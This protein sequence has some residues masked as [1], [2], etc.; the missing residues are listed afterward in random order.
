MLRTAV[1]DPRQRTTP[2]SAHPTLRP[3]THL[4]SLLAHNPCWALALLVVLALPATL[5]LFRP[6][7]PDANDSL[8]HL[9][10]LVEFDHALRAG[11]PFPRWLPDYGLGHGALTTAYYA[12]G[13]Y[14]LAE[15]LH[16]AGLGFPMALNTALALGLLASG[17]A[18]YPLALA[19]TRR[20][21]AAVTAGL[22]YVYFPYHLTDVYT[23]GAIGDASA[24]PLLPLLL[25][26]TYRLAR[27]A[28]PAFLA[29]ASACF[30]LLLFTHE[31]SALLAAPVSLALAAWVAWRKPGGIATCGARRRR[32]GP[33]QATARTLGAVALGFGLSGFYSLPALLE[34]DLV[35]VRG[36]VQ[37]GMGALAHLTPVTGLVQ[38]Q[39]PFDHL[40]LQYRLGLAQIALTCLALLLGGAAALWRRPAL[41]VGWR[42]LAPFLAV[43]IVLG[44][45]MMSDPAR[46]LWASAP[47]LPFVQFPWRVLMPIGLAGAL[48]CSVFA[49]LGRAS[50][51]AA[52]LALAALA[53]ASLWQ[54]PAGRLD[55]DG[56]P[57]T[58]GTVARFAYGRGPD[59]AGGPS[60]EDW[61]P[62]WAN[63]DF[64]KQADGR[65]FNLEAPPAPPLG[66]VR[67]VAWS[68]T[69]HELMVTAPAA[70]PLRFH[71]F[72]H[73]AWGAT[74]D[75]R[76]ARLY[77]STRAGLL[78]LDLPEGEHRVVVWLGLTWGEAAG[79]ALTWVSVAVALALALWRRRLPAFGSLLP[80]PAGRRRLAGPYRCLATAAGYAVPV[81][82]LA[83][84]W[85]LGLAWLTPRAPS[86]APVAEGVPG[87]VGSTVGRVVSEAVL[88][89][90][91]YRLSAS[92]L[93]P[94]DDCRF[95]A[96]GAGTAE[97]S[98]TG[99]QPLDLDLERAGQVVARS[100]AGP[101]FGVS[102]PATWA[103]N[104][105][106][107]DRRE[108]ALPAG[109]PGSAYHLQLR[110]PGGERRLARLA[111]PPTPPLALP[112][113]FHPLEGAEFGGRARLEAYT[114]WTVE[115][116]W[117]PARPAVVPGNTEIG[118]RGGEYLGVALRWRAV[119]PTHEN[120]TV[121][122]HLV[123]SQGRQWAGQDNQPG[124]GLRPTSAWL[125]GEEIDDR[126]LLRL[127]GDLAPGLYRLEVGLYRLATG[128]RLPFSAGGSSLLFSSVKVP[129]AGPPP[130]PG[131][132]V[133]AYFL[134]AGHAAAS[135]EGYDLAPEPARPGA[136]LQVTLHWRAEAT[137]TTDATAF[138][139]LLDAHGKL[140]AQSDSRPANGAYPVLAWA[141]GE[142]IAD[143]HTLAL[144]AALAAGR[145]RLVAGLYDPSG[146]RF[147][148][149]GGGDA[150]SLGEALV[151]G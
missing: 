37:G 29:G 73:P 112:G 38:W 109:Q 64:V 138:V 149:A 132:P 8:D 7:I 91:L 6:G 94:A 52:P 88:P 116:F 150:A 92:A 71:S 141:P 139:H 5:P 62:R 15:A 68:P 9:A 18:T 84:A 53:V 117:R 67:V 80:N 74:V 128:E 46:P 79:Q 134:H 120:A 34:I 143:P 121:F 101:V 13:A 93:P 83:G 56:A 55:V 145:Y 17:P 85:Y 125:P 60:Q 142:A 147:P 27:G 105:V 69:Y 82:L 119:A 130:A 131:H 54:L 11:Q 40:H 76:A 144:P 10:V 89:A 107:D 72:Y 111:L 106:V 127:P 44:L 140:V 118:A 41:P 45:A 51:V 124:G 48:L 59:G 36:M 126:Y 103:P 49:L 115:D 77:P 47:L 22:A 12:P 23:R 86:V 31:V 20:R 99:C 110:W 148:L 102:G 66:R 30:G 28:G 108:L 81:T 58:P 137:L 19:L 78:T 136:P 113:P 97:P 61:L 151:G 63:K 95:T 24:A 96:A 146:Q 43:G 57:L 25:F 4:L 70:A 123:D 90:T 32:L 16:L 114:L 87:V 133:T 135:L 21:A 39:W 14:Y 42:A 65:L 26:F 122:V 2:R 100:G 1:P 33:A 3:S 75:G 104:E 129:L 35:Q 50:W 98:P